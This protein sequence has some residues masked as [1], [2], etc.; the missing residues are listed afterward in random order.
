MSIDAEITVFNRFFS[1]CVTCFSAVFLTG[2]AV[3]GGQ[4][5]Q[6]TASNGI[7]QAGQGSSHTET[8]QT[9]IENRMQITS[10]DHIRRSTGVKV[11]MLLPVSARNK[12]S[13]MARALKQAGELAL[14]DF[15]N[16]NITLVVKD[17]KGTADGARAAA[18]DALNSGAQII[19]GPLYAKSVTAV[20]A[21]AKPKNIPVIAFSSDGRVASEDVY[22]QS[23]LPGDD[24]ERIVAY[25]IGQGKRRFAAL[26]PQTTYGQIV[27][28]KFRAAVEKHGGQ[29]VV[30]EHSPLNPNGMMKPMERIAAFASSKEEAVPQVDAIFLPFGRNVMPTLSPLLP[31]FE[32]DTKVVKVLGTGRWDYAAIGRE[33]SLVN[34]WYPAPDPKGWRR[35]NQKY[36]TTYGKA[37]PRIA[38]LS[39]DAVSLAVALSNNPSNQRFSRQ[40]LTRSSGFAGVDGLFR[41]RKDGTLDR[42]LAVL[43]VK[44]LG[45]HVIDQAATVFGIPAQY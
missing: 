41:L 9:V 24:V 5:A 39:Y 22:L 13:V 32:I 15:D 34:G 42:A 25:A 36:V 10:A 8:T 16:P 20:A 11:A 30:L 33:K 17:T 2:C 44:K 29:I 37:S 7:A 1:V 23:F 28:N 40:E 43:E 26:I 3:S 38:S 21:V 27:E 12:A 31:Y 19:L 45:S 6:T 35:F 4:M 18:Q 14:F